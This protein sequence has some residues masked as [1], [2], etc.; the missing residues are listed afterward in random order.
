MM[1]QDTIHA[2]PD[3]TLSGNI[4]S[5][6]HVEI[7]SDPSTEDLGNF[8][9]R[10][11][12]SSETPPNITHPT[13]LFSLIPHSG[14]TPHFQEYFPL[15][16]VFSGE[17]PE[18]SIH[19]FLDK[20]NEISQ[21]AGW[22]QDHKIFVTKSKLTS[23]A[24]RFLR[25]QPQLKNSRVFADL[26]K[27]LVS[28][29][30]PISSPQNDLL[31]FTTAVQRVGESNRAYLTRLSGLAHKCFTDD[32]KLRNRLLINQCMA[33]FLPNVRRFIMAQGPKS[34]EE[35][36]QLAVR[37][38]EVSALEHNSTPVNAAPIAQSHSEL[39][40]IRDLLKLSI[41]T[42]DAKID[43][44]SKELNDIRVTMSSSRNVEN[45]QRSRVS[46]FPSIIKCFRCQK[47]GHI[48]KNCRVKLHQNNNYRTPLN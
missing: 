10:E 36:W 37:E 22:T 27:A 16:P 15:I 47:T 9:L 45:P 6:N 33:G 46:Q 44:L 32:D 24:S 31:S 7:N 29:F 28:R 35:I 40:E 8:T 3:N 23:E 43:K 42:Q 20:I 25:S 30:C 5:P 48:A 34:Y 41:Q 38:E 13:Q 2:N 14:M 39:A 21:F 1:D 11:N 17:N 4:L 18:V 26:Q 12:M 19:D